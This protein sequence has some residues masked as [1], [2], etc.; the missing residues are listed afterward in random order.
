VSEIL[1]LALPARSPDWMEAPVHRRISS[2][3]LLAGERV[4]LIQ[5]G[6]EE[7]RLRLTAGGKLILTP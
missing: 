3:D 5:H 2:D 4:V 1:Q 7:Y 6:G